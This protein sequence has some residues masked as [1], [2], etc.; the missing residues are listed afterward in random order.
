MLAKVVI[1]LPCLPMSTAERV[2]FQINTT[3]HQ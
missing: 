1:M 3:L 2:S